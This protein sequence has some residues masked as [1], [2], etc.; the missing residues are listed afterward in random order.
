MREK[1]LVVDGSFCDTNLYPDGVQTVA[2]AKK[3]GRDFCPHY[4]ECQGGFL[5]THACVMLYGIEVAKESL[6]SG[7]VA[8]EMREFRREHFVPREGWVYSLDRKEFKIVPDGEQANLLV[9]QFAHVAL[10]D[11]KLPLSD[12]AD[13]PRVTVGDRFED[14]VAHAT[15]VDPQHGSVIVLSEIDKLEGRFGY[16]GGRGCDVR[17]GPC[18]CGAWH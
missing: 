1:R 12:Q 7:S 14:V 9:E 2:E 18:S 11:A 6:K 15:R 16:N 5:D 13:N 10:G 3:K 4:K 8:V 17:S